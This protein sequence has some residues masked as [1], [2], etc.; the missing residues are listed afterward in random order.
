MSRNDCLNCGRSEFV[1]R[2]ATECVKCRKT[3]HEAELAQQL[4]EARAENEALREI[5]RLAGEVVE[6]DQQCKNYRSK[7]Y[8][9][10]TP[11]TLTVARTN[12]IDALRKA[13]E[14][15]NDER[16]M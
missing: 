11:L 7:Q 10:L 6:S 8:L 5:D 16:S 12:A 14:E 1:W 3:K 9:G 2:H 4:A 15:M 13:R